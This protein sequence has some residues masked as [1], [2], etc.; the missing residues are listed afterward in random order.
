MLS[1]STIEEALSTLLKAT[2]REWSESEFFDV[3]TRRGIALHAVVP[4]TTETTI[5]QFRSG[6]GLV[7]K[8]RLPPGHTLLAMLFPF[9][10][11]RLWMAGET[12]T[13][14]PQD[15]DRI[16]GEYKFLVEPILVTRAVVRIK[17]ESLWAIIGIWNDA[18]A[19]LPHAVA[20]PAWMYAPPQT[21]AH[22]ALKISDLTGHPIHTPTESGPTTNKWDH[23]G[24]QRLLEESLQAGATHQKLAEKYNVTR[25]RIGALL[26]QAKPR[27]ASPFAA[28]ERGVPRK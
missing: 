12:Q 28:L 1:I 25:Q 14:H 7:E 3:V 22:D 4:S 13:S 6:E 19:G 18:Q 20:L 21:E 26:K 27:K 8:H 16:S 5:Q 23:H 9:Q 10:V 15:H 11:A 2:G 24:L 17:E